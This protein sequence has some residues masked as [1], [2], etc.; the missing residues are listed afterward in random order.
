MRDS[1]SFVYGQLAS[2]CLTVRDKRERARARE[3]ERERERES[4]ILRYEYGIIYF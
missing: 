4:R 1:F 3:R 2:R